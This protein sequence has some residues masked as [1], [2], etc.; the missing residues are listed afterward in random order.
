MEALVE[1]YFADYLEQETLHRKDVDDLAKILKYIDKQ[2]QKHG[3]NEFEFNH[4]AL[5][6]LFEEYN[7]KIVEP[8]QALNSPE[9]R[10]KSFFNRQFSGDQRSS[11]WLKQ[12]MNYITASVVACCAG[13]T[14]KS[15]RETELLNKAT[16]GTYK[17][18]NGTYYTERGNIFEEV[19][20]MYYCWKNSCLIYEFNLI[21]HDDPEFYFLGASTDGVTNHL[22]NIEIKTL[23][24]IN[25]K[26][27]KKEYWHQM[28]L[29]MSCLNLKCTDFL[30]AVY[31]NDYSD[32]GELNGLD[33]SLPRGVIL[34]FFHTQDK[35]FHY[36]YSPM[37]C[38]ENYQDLVTWFQTKMEEIANKKE[39]DYLVFTRPVFWKMQDYSCRRV[40]KDPNWLRDIGPALKE[41]WASVEE[42]RSNPLELA[43]RTGKITTDVCL[44]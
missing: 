20:N 21:P 44:L 18:F 14:S 11:E 31:K 9:E 41:F 16:F 1:S 15:A 43:R 27:F 10:I 32:I 38:W 12:R 13:L 34:E 8:V 7:V 37:N 23:L 4:H 25:R 24:K 35:Y 40:D 22:V 33:V 17:R 19:T 6:Q 30:E 28:Q 42:L 36:V 2:L 3:M 5:L 26:K 39:R 29:Q